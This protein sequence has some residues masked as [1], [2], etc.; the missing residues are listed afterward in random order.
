MQYTGEFLL[1]AP[2][3]ALSSVAKVPSLLADGDYGRAAAAVLPKVFRDAAKAIRLSESG[4]TTSKGERIDGGV[5]LGVT[6][7][8][9]QALGFQPGRVAEV[10]E[11]RN[12]VKSAERRFN[13]S[14]EGLLRE[15]RQAP[16]EDRGAVWER[17]RS[18]NADTPA[19]GRITYANARAALKES[20]R[21]AQESG[22]GTYVA[23]NRRFLQ[24]EGAYAN[25][26]RAQ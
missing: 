11:E 26:G 1:G 23:K 10:Y 6:E 20:A 16:A 9:M 8:A 7:F 3:G 25:T 13:D 17:I 19:E 5:P 12:A 18:F 24:G 14:R 21:R 22:Q 15:Y 4:V 2:G